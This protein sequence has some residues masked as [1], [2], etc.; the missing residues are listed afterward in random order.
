MAESVAPVVPTTPTTPTAPADQPA[1]PELE[2]QN[3]EAYENVAQKFSDTR[4]KIWPSTELFLLKIN[5]DFSSSK[6]LEVGC[7]NGKNI[8]PVFDRVEF[9]GT[10][11]CGELLDICRHRGLNV[12]KSDGCSLPFEDDA[13]DHVMS[14][15]V[16]HHLSTTERR[17]EF[18]REMIRVCKN[19]RIMFQVWSKSSPQYDKS[20]PVEGGHPDDRRVMFGKEKRYYHF[21]DADSFNEMI[22]RHPELDGDIREEYDNWIFEGKITKTR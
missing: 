13:F 22:S 5:K 19:G 21:F 10:D 14:I 3:L 9:T 16:I 12:V 2:R 15:A 11:I 20:E 8:M 6:V 17:D 18:I 1:L 4:Y 7:G